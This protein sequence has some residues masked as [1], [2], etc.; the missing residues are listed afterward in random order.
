MLAAGAA[1]PLLDRWL[2]RAAGYPLAAV[3]AGVLVWLLTQ[4]DG[5]LSGGEVVETYQWVPALD[6]SL[7][8]RLDGLSLLF[9][10]LVLGVGALVMSYTPRYLTP[11]SHGRLFI[12]LRSGGV[13]AFDLEDGTEPLWVVPQTLEQ[14]HEERLVVGRVDGRRHLH[15]QRLQLDVL[16]VQG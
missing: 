8:L 10:G 14:V 1:A 5:V 6:V 12:V 4:A 15:P 3:F 13:A 11:G 9:V 7:T 2:G 16:P